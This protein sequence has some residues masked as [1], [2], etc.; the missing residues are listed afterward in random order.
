MLVVQ[1]N[2]KIIELDPQ[3]VNVEK[4][5]IHL[6][7]A[8]RENLLN[9]LSESQRNVLREFKKYNMNSALLT[10]F[11]S[12][13][14]EWNLIEER[15]NYNFDRSRPANSSLHCAC[16]RGVKYLYICKSNKDGKTKGFGIDHLTQEAGISKEIVAQVRVEKHKIDRGMDEILRQIEKGIHFPKDKYDY[17]VSNDTLKKIFSKNEIKYLAKFYL[18]DLPIYIQDYRKMGNQ[19]KSIKEEEHQ[20]WLNT[21]E[22]QEFTRKQREDMK[23]RILE[24]EEIIDNR[25]TRSEEPEENPYWKQ[26]EVA[27]GDINIKEAKKVF[28]EV[29]SKHGDVLDKYD[30]SNEK[31]V[32]TFIIKFMF[33]SGDS[34]PGRKIIPRY[35]VLSILRGLSKKF[36]YDFD[37]LDEH[38]EKLFQILSSENLI[39]KNRDIWISN[40]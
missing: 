11:N 14:N 23:K 34:V 17:L 25:N 29:F 24:W 12:D 16:G 2:I 19:I 9:K 13:G 20:K 27:K 36:G 30:L 37:N 7:R 39:K 35:T 38:Y 10:N 18:E 33:N 15:I 26:S 22:G 8:E 5:S 31:N 40:Y 28:D 1:E 21:P 3:I 32:D 4:S 6:T